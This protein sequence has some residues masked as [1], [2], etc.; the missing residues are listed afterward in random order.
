MDLRLEKPITL[1]LPSEAP[2][3]VVHKHTL[4]GLAATRLRCLIVWEF[5]KGLDKALCKMH[6][7]RISVDC[8]GF[9]QRALNL[10]MSVATRTLP[11]HRIRIQPS[12]QQSELLPARRVEIARRN[13]RLL[14][15]NGKKP[16]PSRKPSHLGKSRLLQAT[17][18]L[19]TMADIDYNQVSKSQDVAKENFR[20][21]TIPTQ[22]AIIT[23]TS[24]VSCWRE[25][26]AR[27]LTHCRSDIVVGEHVDQPIQQINV[28]QVVLQGEAKVKDWGYDIAS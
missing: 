11:G 24:W 10:N 26:S 28:D 6:S 19:V 21:T 4:N 17:R 3:Q 13:N 25:S 8:R 23:S 20:R 1:N 15:S 14:A 27:R 22:R 18:S 5:L 12:Q 2:Q 16:P 9:C 7:Q